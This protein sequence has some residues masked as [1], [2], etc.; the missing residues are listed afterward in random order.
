MTL[1]PKVVL[2]ERITSVSLDVS[3]TVMKGELLIAYHD[4]TVDFV[5]HAVNAVPAL[6][7]RNKGEGAHNIIPNGCKRLKVE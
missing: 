4:L 5:D 3:N 1:C 2:W 7:K 6:H